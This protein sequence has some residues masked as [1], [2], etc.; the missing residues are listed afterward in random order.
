MI[1]KRDE[2]TKWVGEALEQAFL[3]DRLKETMRIRI[4]KFS[5]YEWLIDK[6]RTGEKPSV[7]PTLPEPMLRQVELLSHLDN[8]T[9]LKGVGYRVT[10]KIFYLD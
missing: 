8:G 10:D 9:E 7:V 5:Q 6:L 2:M 1:L 4:E 3:E